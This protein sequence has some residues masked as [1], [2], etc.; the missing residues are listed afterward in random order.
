MACGRS[1][2][3]R[4]GG[5]IVVVRSAGRSDGGGGGGGGRHGGR[6]KSEA[7]GSFDSFLYWSG[8]ILVS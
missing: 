2:E 5:L 3:A 6:K 8:M 4:E 7:E 1:S